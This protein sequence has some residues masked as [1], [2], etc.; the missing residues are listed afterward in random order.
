VCK[1]FIFIDFRGSCANIGRLVGED[2]LQNFTASERSKIR[3]Q[4][5]IHGRVT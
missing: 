2:F 1:L 3:K 5:P 4:D